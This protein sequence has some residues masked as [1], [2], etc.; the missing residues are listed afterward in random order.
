MKKLFAFLIA[1]IMLFS[2]AACGSDDNDRSDGQNE[3][4]NASNNDAGS[5]ND[6]NISE[7]DAAIDTLEQLIPEGWDEN[8]YGAYIY[9]VWDSEFLPDCFPDA[10]E[11][12]KVDQTTFKDYTHDTLNGDYAVGPLYYESKED[13]REYG[14]FFYATEEQLDAFTGAVEAKGMEGG[15]TEEGEWTFYNYFGNGWFMEIFVREALSEDDYQYSVSVSATDSLFELPASIDGIPLPQCGMTE[16]DYNQYYTIQ[17]F[18]NGYEDVDFDLSSDT[19]PSEYYA[20]WF[21]YYCAANQDAIDYAQQL[22][23]LGWEVEW[24]S[25][26]EDGYRCCLH[27]DGIYAI[28]NYYDYDCLLEVGFSDMV[29]NLSY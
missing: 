18:T 22:K 23:D 11:G 7:L 3:D 15:I 27:K 16:S 9:N 14:V 21:N 13:Y 19:L 10:P 29:E 5:D 20:A 6:I 17:D 4:S 28:S 12:I 2:L 26:G 25:D 8:S 1:L 24:E